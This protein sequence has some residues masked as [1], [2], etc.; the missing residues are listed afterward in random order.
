M[1]DNRLQSLTEIFNQK[2]FRVPDFQ[3]GYSWQEEHLEDFWG[4]L[5]NLKENKIHYTGLLTV[6]PVKKRTIDENKKW[7]SDRWLSEKGLSAYYVVDGQQR[8]TTVIIFIN[9]LLKRFEDSERINYAKKDDWKRKFLYDQYGEDVQYKSYLFGY[10]KDNPSD[11]YFK[12]KILEQE[13]S[14]ADKVPEQTLYTANLKFAKE[15]FRQK[16]E[17]KGKPVLEDLFKKVT[18]SFKFNFLRN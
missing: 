14:T 9:E 3:R 17:G 13:S 4:D 7:R 8:L 5:T 12:T 6:E 15:F 18:N 16:F 2:F 10:E 11:E 1:A